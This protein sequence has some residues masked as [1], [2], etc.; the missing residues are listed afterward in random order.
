MKQSDSFL[1]SI[2]AGTRP[3]IIKL[4][5]V[6]L[7]CKA[8]KNWSTNL[9]IT[10]Q[11]RDLVTPFLKVFNIS[12]EC[13]LGLLHNN[14]LVGDI[15]GKMIVALSQELSKVRPELV[16]V[17]GD[18][19]SALAGALAAF[20]LKIPVAHVEAGLRTN[21]F[22][23]PFPEEMNRVLISKIAEL[24]FA[25]TKRALSNL[26][27]E[28]LK[29][30]LYLTGNTGVDALELIKNNLSH[31]EL[32]SKVVE[33]LESREKFILT[34]FH[35]RE[36]Q[37]DYFG[38]FLELLS[39]AAKYTGLKI[40]IPVHLSPNVK[41]TL[42]SKFSK[43]KNIVLLPPVDYP[44]LIALMNSC[45]TIISDSGG[46]QEEAPSL[47]KHVFIART[48]TERPE[49]IESGY[50]ELLD[51][52]NPESSARRISEFLATNTSPNIAPNPFGDGTASKQI[53]EAIIS[54]KKPKSG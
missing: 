54:W 15:L 11:H 39:L 42:H 8:E 51:L 53:I 7:A 25:P 21:N 41:D 48:S 22:S 47:G 52:P 45:E 49:V 24:H 50:G 30:G 6:Y 12:P 37:D 5:P 32:D 26:K 40:V 16:V 14:S 38:E 10:G 9:I 1:I 23:S 17:Q 2:I 33:L 27:A 46:I 13:D 4:A 31:Y 18:T 44:N 28:G 3:E 43:E 36:N 20:H 35:R 34:T 19:S 29:E